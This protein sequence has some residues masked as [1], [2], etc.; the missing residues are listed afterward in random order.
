MTEAEEGVE[1]AHDGAVRQLL[2]LETAFFSNALEGTGAEEYGA[3]ELPR[4]DFLDGTLV[5]VHGFGHGVGDGVDVDALR[6]DGVDMRDHSAH[7]QHGRIAARH[8]ER[9]VIGLGREKEGEDVVALGFRQLTFRVA[10]D[11]DVGHLSGCPLHGL[12]GTDAF[13]AVAAAG[14]GDQQDLAVFVEVE[15][16]GRQDVGR[17]EGTGTTQG[18]VEE[19]GLE[20]VSDIGGGAGAGQDDF[21]TGRKETVEESGDVIFA[22]ANHV[23]RFTP[24]A[25]L[26]SD[27][28]ISME[29]L[30]H[31]ELCGF[32]HAN[33]NKMIPKV[34]FKGN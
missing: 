31:E 15:L 12:D 2:E 1:G 3:G 9:N 8:G 19:S 24:D 23:I 17:R 7:Q 25:G 26:L 20:G 16:G 10:G 13:G 14:E 5:A 32:K 21:I 22:C 29:L 30:C 28:A 6:L 18:R 4:G 27:F 11:E 34:S 33:I